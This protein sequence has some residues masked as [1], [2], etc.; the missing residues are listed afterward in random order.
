[1]PLDFAVALPSHTKYHVGI[2][3]SAGNSQRDSKEQGLAA[4]T[5]PKYI[6]NKEMLYIFGTFQVL[7][8]VCALLI[9]AMKPWGKKSKASPST[10]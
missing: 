6:H 7:T 4:L 1:M 2:R 3:A 5:D 9:S 8:L 10:S